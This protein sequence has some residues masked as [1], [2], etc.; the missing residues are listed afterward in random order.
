MNKTINKIENPLENPF[1]NK[2]I[3]NDKTLKTTKIKTDLDEFSVKMHSKNEWCLNFWKKNEGYMRINEYLTRIKSSAGVAENYKNINNVNNVYFFFKEKLIENDKKLEDI[4]SCIKKQ[5]KPI[6]DIP[7]V[8]T[9]SEFWRGDNNIFDN[10][11]CKMETFISVTKNRDVA[12]SFG[13]LF[14]IFIN[15]DVKCVTLFEKVQIY[16]KEEEIL[17]EDDC[18]WEIIHKYKKIVRIHSPR[19]KLVNFPYRSQISQNVI[20]NTIF[21]EKTLLNAKKIIQFYCKS[22]FENILNAYILSNITKQNVGL[23]KFKYEFFLQNF[24]IEI[25]NNNNIEFTEEFEYETFNEFIKDIFVQEKEYYSKIFNE[26]Y[27]AK[28]NNVFYSKKSHSKHTL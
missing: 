8:A 4:V 17:L 25:L 24:K 5:M 12:R 16:V 21:Q 11:N 15:P 14:Q 9:L 2:F 3:K 28:F 22:Y 26:I 6:G 20:K 10:K 13:D 7:I 19:S 27:L 23:Y 18:Y 1:E